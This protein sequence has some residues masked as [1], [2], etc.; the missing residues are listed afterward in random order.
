[1]TSFF[2]V[3]VLFGNCCF[4]PAPFDCAQGTPSTTLR[5]RLRL[6]SGNAFDCAQGTLRLSSGNAFDYAHG[7]RSTAL[8]ERFDC[9]QGTPSTTLRERLRLRPR[10]DL[11]DRRS[12]KRFSEYT[13]IISR[14]S[15][16]K[17]KN[18][19]QGG[20][21]RKVPAKCEVLVLQQVVA[22]Y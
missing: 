8:R 3:F 12:L 2:I 11:F 6:R 14:S 7:T 10:N 13:K 9:A 22:L 20:K 17:Q 5:E 21:F 4:C 16:W 19:A 15:G 18:Q 1:M